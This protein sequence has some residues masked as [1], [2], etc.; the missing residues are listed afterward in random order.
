MVVILGKLVFAQHLLFV[1]CIFGV[2]VVASTQSMMQLVP[3]LAVLLPTA[4][5]PAQIAALFLGLLAQASY[6]A[7]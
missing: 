1:A 4:M 3:E 6:I 2:H 5:D 7:S